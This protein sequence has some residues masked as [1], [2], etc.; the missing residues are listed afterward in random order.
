MGEVIGNIVNGVID[1]INR[2]FKVAKDFMEELKSCQMG[3]GIRKAIWDGVER[4]VKP[5]KSLMIGIC[6]SKKTS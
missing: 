1:I 5:Q 2:A 4:A 3:N 6:T